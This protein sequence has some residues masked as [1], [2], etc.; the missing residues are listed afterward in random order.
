MRRGTIAAMESGKPSIGHCALRGLRLRCPKCG[1]GRLFDGWYTVRPE[2]PACHLDFDACQSNTWAF[3]YL[4]TAFL[5][6]LFFVAM[7]LIRPASLLT[8][9]AVVFVAGLAIIAGS[10]PFRKSLAMALEFVIDSRWGSSVE[11]SREPKQPTNGEGS[12]L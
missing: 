6:G 7:L 2:C 1:A 11:D 5:T 12:P 10:L 4:S 3:M 9:R 8:G